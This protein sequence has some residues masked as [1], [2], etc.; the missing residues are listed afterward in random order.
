MTSSIIY[1]LWPGIKWR[2]W[3]L[4]DEPQ[5][6]LYYKWFTCGLSRLLHLSSSEK[7]GS[8]TR[9]FLNVSATSGNLHSM[10]LYTW[11]KNCE[12]KVHFLLDHREEKIVHFL[13]TVITY[14]SSYQIEVFLP[15]GV[16]IRMALKRSEGVS[17]MLTASISVKRPKGWHFP[18]ISFT[19]FFCNA[20]FISRITLSIM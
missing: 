4:R 2:V 6:L 3:R 13:I 10:L 17:A 8:W 5:F 18:R 16:S 7:W 14:T 9:W 1:L 15:N 12:I 20:P 19:D 11:K